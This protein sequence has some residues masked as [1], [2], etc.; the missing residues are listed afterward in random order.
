MLL[1]LLVFQAI[2]L[3]AVWSR[4]AGIQAEKWPT[5]Q[6]LT[7]GVTR[8]LSP[9]AEAYLGAHGWRVHTLFA[10]PVEPSGCQV[11]PGCLGYM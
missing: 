5:E 9:V 3:A 11:P 2:R 10:A 6:F 7:G 1:V 8:D 4:R